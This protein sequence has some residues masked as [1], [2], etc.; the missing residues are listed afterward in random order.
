MLNRLMLI[1]KLYC[2]LFKTS[3]DSYV[4]EMDKWCSK[5]KTKIPFLLASSLQFTGISLTNTDKVL[6]PKVQNVD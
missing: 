5:L 2:F 1:K 4:S 6:C 3:V